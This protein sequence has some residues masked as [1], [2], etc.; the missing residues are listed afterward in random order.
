MTATHLMFRPFALRW[1]LVVG[2]AGWYAFATPSEAGAQAGRTLYVNQAADDGGD[3]LSAR[4]AFRTIQQAADAAMPG[5][6]ILVAP[7]V[8]YEHVQI[9]RG[10]EPGRPIT[11][12]AASR[13]LNAVVITG[14]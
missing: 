8:Y 11:F 4:R 9:T 10:G 6:T 14:A 3:G 2:L 5:D 13:E 12:R 1:M 7:G